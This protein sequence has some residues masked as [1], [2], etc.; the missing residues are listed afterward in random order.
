MT[1]IVLCKIDECGNL[2]FKTDDGD[3]W[4]VW[5]DWINDAKTPMVE[6]LT[7]QQ[8]EAMKPSLDEIW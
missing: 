5:V 8:V 3:V 1:A 6:C 2:F 4:H 7:A